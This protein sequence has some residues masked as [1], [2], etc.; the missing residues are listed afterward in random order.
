M[1]KHVPLCISLFIFGLASISAFAGVTVSSP[2]NGSTVGSSV[3]IVASANTSC[4]KGIAS[5]GIYPAP[6]WLVYTV[7][8]ASLNTNIS[9]N[10]GTYNVVVEEWDKCGGASTATV[11]INVKNA[12]NAVYVTSPAN[13]SSSG[14]S[15]NFVATATSA[16]SLGVAS[17]GIYTAPY[18]LAYVTNGASLNTSLNLS[19]GTYNTTVQEWDKCGGAATAQVTV[20]VGGN[21]F[22]H[23]QSDGG[24]N[25]YAQQPPT[26]QD[27]TNCT[28]SGPGTTWAMY[29]GI[30]SPSLSG[31][32][33]QFNLGGNM[34]YSDVLW[35]NHLIGDFSSQGMPD[36]NHTLVPTLSTFTYDVYFYSGQI[37]NAQALE[38]DI[39]QFFNGMGFTW[40]HECRVSGGNEWD[41]W[42]NGNN[43]W[44]PTGIPCYPLT[45]Q[46]NHL[47]LQVQ[48]TPGNQLLYQSITFNGATYTLNKYSNN[49]SAPGWYGIT[50]NYQMDGNYG[51]WAYDVYVD[52]LNFTY[53]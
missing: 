8:G 24:W 23:I 17:M 39:N 33:T 52:N 29:Q 50:I 28:P 1:K 46:W 6:Y 26:Y 44:V 43:K 27:C 12:A 41:Y 15:V 37:N 22:P 20:K 2:A 36:T 11:T 4:S 30:K 9:L 49:F 13:N 3:N 34:P 32:A 19:P 25:G 5:M 14:S 18:Q 10:P 31:N 16:C 7:G 45:N 21:L 40:G 35:N 53:Q 38:F 51:Q 48:R 47:I 42:D